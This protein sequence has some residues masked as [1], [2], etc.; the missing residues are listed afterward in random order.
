M[1]DLR[2]LIREIHR[3]SLWQVLAIY[4]VS[5]WVVLQ[6]VDTLAGALGL[7]EWA[8][9]LALFLLVVGLPIV[10]AT[11]FVQEGIGAPADV[12]A[13]KHVDG[14]PRSDARD[15]D[16]P[17]AEH[18]SIA[19]R[20]TWRRA[21]LGG[22]LAFSVLLGVAGL[23]AVFDADER[24][25][26]AITSA[27]EA[28]PA[29][30]VLP[31]TVRGRDVDIWREGMVDLLSPMLDGVPGL[32]A[33]NSRTVLSRWNRHVGTAEADLETSLAV[34]REAGARFALIGSA[35]GG[36]PSVRVELELYDVDT[37]ERLD[38][39]RVDGASG[40]LMTLTDRAAAEAAR[41]VLRNLGR[42]PDFQ[43]ESLTESAEALLAFLEGE[44][45]F[46]DYR[47][48][49]A[50]NA[51]ERAVR[52][53]TA[54]AFAHLRLT[55]VA[56]WGV[57]AGRP[58]GQHAQAAARHVDRLTDRSAVRVRAQQASGVDR[59]RILR[60]AVARYPD[61]AVL[62]YDLG[63]AL[64][65]TSRGFPELEE[66][67]AA[68][69]R[70]LELEPGRAATYPHVVHLAFL[71]GTD[72]ARTRSLVREFGGLAGDI[73][74]RYTV[75]VDPRIGP[76]AFDLAF[77]NPTEKAAAAAA[78]D[79][80]PLDFLLGETTYTYAPRLWDGFELANLAV[81][82]RPG[83]DRMSDGTFG[84]TMEGTANRR[85]LIG[86]A[87]W[88]G[89]PQRGLEFAR[90]RNLG[91]APFA[92][93]ARGLLYYMHA[94]GLPI[95]DETLEREFGAAR[96]D[97]GTDEET[98]FAAGAYAADR[99]RWADHETAIRELHGGDSAAAEVLEAYGAWRRGDV[100]AAIPVFERRHSGNRLVQWWLGDA[101]L[102]A[103]RPQD[104]ERVFAS[105]GWNQWFIAFNRN[106]L[107]QRR[108]GAIYELLAR[109]EDA[110]RAYAYFL[111]NWEDA[112]PALQPLVE[113]TRRR[114]ERL[115]AGRG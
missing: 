20:L 66:I 80:L 50:W 112:E 115:L 60:D 18:G 36:G 30:A 87:L 51:Y 56:Q 62:W 95:P 72:T 70:A 40:D 33:I 96:I 83:A 106:P 37:G 69:D 46:R 88:R 107:A 24:N 74:G 114:M 48:V 41:G 90:G 97:S 55:E 53:D 93:D 15:A 58:I 78:A 13:P 104:A 35:V 98:I 1:P 100:D 49:D 25:G 109:P 23:F 92:T 67:Q 38:S 6:V 94:L 5:G 3:R 89:R 101:Y 77:G 32:R 110:I 2:R 73:E 9:P 64:I 44:V 103:G 27:T 102:D 12:D 17:A 84:G 68:F 108:L 54:F 85:L 4:L 75:D 105:Y 52:A 45:A 113:D 29:V 82:R 11:A 14:A 34:A 57:T 91:F 43:L 8:A 61:D 76:Y 81:S 71:E 22:V 86:Y 42:I 65:H 31:F 28:D 111:D 26:G 16:Q 7:P 59:Q 99:G 47:L 19:G 39:R 63:E 10:L 21:L 79:T